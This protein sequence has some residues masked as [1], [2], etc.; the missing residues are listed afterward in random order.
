MP[1]RVQLTVPK[2]LVAVA[3]AP[4]AGE[5]L[6]ADAWRVV[7]FAPTEAIPSY[8]VAYAVGPF[9]IVE[10]GKSAGGTPTAS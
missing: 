2:E 10:A 3:N 9:D 6:V 1:W 5:E 8:L 7:Q 4:A